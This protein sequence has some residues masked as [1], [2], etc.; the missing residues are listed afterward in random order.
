M[1]FKKDNIPWNKNLTKE[2]DERLRKYGIKISNSKKGCTI[3]NKNLTKENDT[4]VKKYS[5]TRI[6]L[7]LSKVKNNPWFIDGNSGE[8]NYGKEWEKIRE[9]VRKRDNYVCQRCGKTTKENGKQLSVH[10]IIPFRKSKSH[11]LNN[12]TTL[13]IAC[14]NIVEARNI[15]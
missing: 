14:H 9:L 1:V 3:W 12:L 4:R 7:G 11:T 5:E 6:K 13:C 15:K 8:R 10:H 2:T